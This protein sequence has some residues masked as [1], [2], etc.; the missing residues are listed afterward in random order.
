MKGQGL[1]LPAELVARQQETKPNVVAVQTKRGMKEIFLFNQKRP[2]R[3][4]T[5]PKVKIALAF[6]GDAVGFNSHAQEWRTHY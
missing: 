6:Y 4:T 5:H 1:A 2:R 3:L